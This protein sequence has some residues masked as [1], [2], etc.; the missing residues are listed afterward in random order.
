MCSAL[1]ARFLYALGDKSCYPPGAERIGDNG[2]FGMYHSK[3]DDH[4]KDVI[5]KSMNQLD[6]VISGCGEEVF[7]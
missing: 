3:T 5:M 6:G 4:N 1:Y 7:R 2:L